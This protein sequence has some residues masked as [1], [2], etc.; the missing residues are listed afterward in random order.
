MTP[1]RRGLLF[2]VLAPGLGAVGIALYLILGG[3]TGG[4]HW[5]VVKA[6]YMLGPALIAV[7]MARFID[8]RPVARTLGLALPPNR[9]YLTAWLLPFA[10]VGLTLLVSLALPGIDFS[11]DLS[12]ALE[13]LTGRLPPERLAEAR[14]QIARLGPP[15]LFLIQLAQALVAGL[16]INAL[17][18][19]GEEAGWR[20]YLLRCWASLGFSR[21][22]VAIGL[23]W[24]LWHAPLVL[25]GHNYPVH[26]RLGVLLF[27]LICVELSILFLYVRIRARSTLAA[28]VMHGSLNACAG[29]AH[30]YV[31]GGDDLLVGVPGLA[32]LIALALA[33]LALWPLLHRQRAAIDAALAELAATDAGAPQAPQAP[34]D[35]PST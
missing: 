17:F 1:L 34:G 2:A 11:P 15:L 33:G 27:T 14:L 6:L 30:A 32:G 5:L 28:A 23:V 31:R 24:G 12:G 9:H 7:A 20:G 22:A 10:L 29:F 26:R 25:L 8:R 3:R 16:T 21:A 35:Q 18:A 4:W 19:M 13:Q